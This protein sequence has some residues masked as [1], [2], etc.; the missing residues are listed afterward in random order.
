[1]WFES[2]RR[3]PDPYTE[4]FREVALNHNIK[5]SKLFAI[6]IG[7]FCSALILLDVST[8]SSN[9]FKYPA[10]Y[11]IAIRFIFLSSSVFYFLFL[12]CKKIG[13]ETKYKAYKLLTDSYALVIVISSLWVTFVMQ[14][15]PSNTMSIFVLGILSVAALW[16]FDKKQT[17]LIAAFILILFNGGLHYFQ[18]DG[19]K[20]LANYITGTC[21][22]I[23]FVCISRLCFSMNFRHFRQLKSIEQSNQ[24]LAK[25]NEMQTE[26]LSVVAHDL[27]SPND[28]IIGLVDILKHPSTTKEEN[29]ELY[30]M[31]LTACSMSKAIIGDLL[32][33]AKYDENSVSFASFSLDDLIENVVVQYRKYTD[34]P[35]R[36]IYNKPP[37]KIYALINKERMMRVFDN[38]L[39]NATK[40]THRD[41]VITITLKCEAGKVSII[42]ADNGIGIPAELIPLLFNKFSK[43]SRVGL[44]GEESH[45]LGLSI[46]KLIMKQHNGDITASSKEGKGTQMTLTLPQ[47]KT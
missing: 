18:T 29:G 37:E 40:F 27:R 36:V 42:V 20:L 25:I 8:R 22:T 17:F 1:M 11:S 28:T 30:D 47:A 21:V 6:I 46:C 2:L 33:I 45:G 10:E 43:A 7:L 15:N 9:V 38:L 24:E 4:A 26:I 16:I 14:H 12:L 34:N 31:I 3:L 41:G 32:H 39:K 19:C 5:T 44:N 13:A 23:F 35:R